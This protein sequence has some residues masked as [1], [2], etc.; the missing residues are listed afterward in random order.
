MPILALT[1]A[2]CSATPWSIVNSTSFLAIDSVLSDRV[3]PAESQPNAKQYHLKSEELV[4]ASGPFASRIPLNT[5][6]GRG[7]VTIANMATPQRRWRSAIPHALGRAARL[8]AIQADQRGSS[9]AGARQQRGRK[10]SIVVH[11]RKRPERQCLPFSS[12][13]LSEVPG[14]LGVPKRERE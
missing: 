10:A 11:Q 7:D 8:A 6:T 14:I 4:R 2:L 12:V 1:L 5:R 3:R 13:R 9:N